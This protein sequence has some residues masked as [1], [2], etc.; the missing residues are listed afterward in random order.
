MGLV[1]LVP[2]RADCNEHHACDAP[3]FLFSIDYRAGLIDSGRK[4]DF[5]WG[6][7]YYVQGMK[8]HRLLL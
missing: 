7:F 1:L 4:L 8:V 3:V 5:S 6:D 2:A